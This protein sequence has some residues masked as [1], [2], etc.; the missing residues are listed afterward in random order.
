MKTPLDGGPPTVLIA[1]QAQP[2]T[3]AVDGTSVYLNVYSSTSDEWGADGIMK[4]T[5]K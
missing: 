5:P 2:R 3:I 1:Q 4:L